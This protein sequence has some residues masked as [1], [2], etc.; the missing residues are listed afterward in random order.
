MEDAAG[1]LTRRFGK[2]LP[3]VR[4]VR[5]AAERLLGA[6]GEWTQDTRRAWRETR[7]RK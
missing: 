2:N 7:K 4:Q 1:D 3:G 6:V 5:K